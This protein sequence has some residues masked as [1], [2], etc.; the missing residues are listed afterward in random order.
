MSDQIVAETSTIQ[1]TRH[2]QQTNSYAPG[3]IRTQNLSMRVAADLRRRGHWD[4]QSC[5]Y[6]DN[7]YTTGIKL[8]LQMDQHRV[9]PSHNNIDTTG[10]NP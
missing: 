1:H 5:P 7:I 4:R 9:L 6:L 10:I 8:E 3:G 2:S